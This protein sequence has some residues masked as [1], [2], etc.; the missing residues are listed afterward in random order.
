VLESRVADAGDAMR[1][2]RECLECAHRMTTYERVEQPALWVAKH[3]GR[4]EPFDRAK[5]LRGLVHACSK[6]DVQIERLEALVVDIETQLRAMHVKAV[7]SGQLGELALAGLYEVDRVAYVR[8]ASVYRAFET[9]DEFHAELERIASGA[10][11]V[12]PTCDL[13]AGTA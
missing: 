5:L 10:A 9:V 2:R 1:R 8:F 7:D 13:T 4:Q 6:R 11:Q 12:G 3:D